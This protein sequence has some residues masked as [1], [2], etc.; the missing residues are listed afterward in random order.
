MLKYLARKRA[1]KRRVSHTQPT[2]KQMVS[3]G[4]D[5]GYPYVSSDEVLVR[6]GVSTQSVLDGWS[7]DLADD[8]LLAIAREVLYSVCE[9]A[10]L[11]PLASSAYSGPGGLVR[12][13][14]R[15]AS[16]ALRA[17]HSYVWVPY[18]DPH[19]RDLEPRWRFALFL[20]GIT[21]W[22]GVPT[23]ALRVCSST[24]HTWQPIKT[25]LAQ[26]LELNGYDTYQVGMLLSEPLIATRPLGSDSLGWLAGHHLP[27]GVAEALDGPGG[28]PFNSLARAWAGRGAGRFAEVLVQAATYALQSDVVGGLANRVPAHAGVPLGALLL[29]AIRAGADQDVDWLVCAEDGMNAWLRWPDAAPVLATVLPAAFVGSQGVQPQYLAALLTDASICRNGWPELLDGSESEYGLRLVSPT[30]AWPDRGPAPITTP[31]THRK[32]DT[33]DGV[34][35][36]KPYPA[37]NTHGQ[38]PNGATSLLQ[39]L[40]T[41]K[42]MAGLVYEESVVWVARTVLRELSDG[43][44]QALRSWLGDEGL[45]EERL[46]EGALYKPREM[47]DRTQPCVAL[48][49][50]RVIDSCGKENTNV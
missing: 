4:K 44:D 48:H 41:R 28:E 9:F 2:I 29:G 25:R 12:I 1:P 11:L 47:D 46:I 31:Q 18:T 14:I 34:V 6:A 8:N 23:I 43:E 30:V 19:R 17:T 32:P 45:V 40:R 39:V 13:A 7:V 27:A 26:W 35:K 24:G 21:W 16:F 5:A 42:K 22:L 3:S 36:Q 38:R 37:E 50:R 10:H 15:T 49:L 33:A 20:G